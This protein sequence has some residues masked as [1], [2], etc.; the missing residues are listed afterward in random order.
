MGLPA[1]EH[2]DFTEHSPFCQVH[3]CYAREVGCCDPDFKRQNNGLGEAQNLPCSC[4]EG[5]F[6]WGWRRGCL[7][8]EAVGKRERLRQ[9]VH[10]PTEWPSSNSIDAGSRGR[11]LLC[12]GEGCECVSIGRYVPTCPFRLNAATGKRRGNAV[13]NA[14]GHALYRHPW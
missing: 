4:L 5:A 2:P 8:V 3:V 12:V 13:A 7:R 14:R 6:E 10:D 1:P 9:Y 11:R